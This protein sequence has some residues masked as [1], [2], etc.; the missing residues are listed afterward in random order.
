MIED[1]ELGSGCI[2]SMGASI[3]P[4]EAQKELNIE[5][6]IKSKM[7]QTTVKLFKPETKIRIKSRV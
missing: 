5:D 2:D 3:N 4:T 6:I 1:I 7:V